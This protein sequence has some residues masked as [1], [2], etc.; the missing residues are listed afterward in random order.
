MSY[1]SNPLKYKCVPP[2][3][4]E[5]DHLRILGGQ[6]VTITHTAPR[7]NSSSPNPLGSQ[8]SHLRT[9]HPHQ[10]QRLDQQ[11]HA[12]LASFMS[13]PF[14]DPSS[15][16]SSPMSFHSFNNAT[17]IE[18]SIPFADIATESTFLSSNV[19]TYEQIMY[20]AAPTYSSAFPQPD[21][22]FHPAPTAYHGNGDRFDQS[23]YAPRGQPM[24][25]MRPANGFG[26]SDRENIWDSFVGDLMTG[27]PHF[28]QYGL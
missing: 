24:D 22:G 2:P 16:G 25:T 15:S 7:S 9:Q 27:S 19:P 18:D 5:L 13:A 23:R 20:S 6:E 26:T 8:V 11:P 21:H 3:P 14:S 28:A 4:G 1:W 10:A 12:S 17:S